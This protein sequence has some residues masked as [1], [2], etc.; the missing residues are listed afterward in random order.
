MYILDKSQEIKYFIYIS[1]ELMK[2]VGQRVFNLF[3]FIFY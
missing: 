3:Y 1:Q 2:A